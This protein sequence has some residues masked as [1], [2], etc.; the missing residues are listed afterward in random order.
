MWAIIPHKNKT[1]EMSGKDR[2]WRNMKRRAEISA[3]RRKL[4]EFKKQ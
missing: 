2:I 3:I 1:N 4:S